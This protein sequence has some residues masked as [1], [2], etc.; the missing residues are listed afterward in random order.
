M[1]IHQANQ[2]PELQQYLPI[3]AVVLQEMPDIGSE[4][5]NDNRANERRQMDDD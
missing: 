5:L 2:Q 4:R 1:I 3:N